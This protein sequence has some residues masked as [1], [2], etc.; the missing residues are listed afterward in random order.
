MATINDRVI[1][2]QRSSEREMQL[3]VQTKNEEIE[4]YPLLMMILK[5]FVS[6]CVQ[7]ILSIPFVIGFEKT[8]NL[9]RKLEIL[10]SKTNFEPFTCNQSKRCA[11][12]YGRVV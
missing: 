8:G 4:L 7:R 11:I 12:S 1:Q 6:V 3:T 10:L 2:L 9:S 5:V